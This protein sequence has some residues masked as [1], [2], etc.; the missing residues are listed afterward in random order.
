M[1]ML[2]AGKWVEKKTCIDV[3]NPFD[4]S[5]ID[6][7]PCADASDV[8]AALEGAVRGAEAMR[9][10]SARERSEILARPSAREIGGLREG[11]RTR[12][13]QDPPRGRGRS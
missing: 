11:H 9:K 10:L 1:K 5:V 4:G 7:V 6:T 13:R 8:E 3:T 2:I 12:G